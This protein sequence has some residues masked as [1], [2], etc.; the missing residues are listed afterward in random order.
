MGP[1]L[2][3][4]TQMLAVVG[5][6]SPV[7]AGQNHGSTTAVYVTGSAAATTLY[8]LDEDLTSSNV[9]GTST[10][11]RNSLWRYDIGTATQ[12]SGLPT[13]VNTAVG[14][15]LVPLASSDL[16]RGANGNFYLAQNRA[17]GNEAGVIVLSADGSTVLFN[18]LD[19][20]RALLANPAAVDIL[21]NI[22]GIAV[23]PDQ[24]YLAGMLNNS[25]VVVLRLD[26]LGI[27]DLAN[28]LVIDTGTDIIS[29]RD[30]TFDAA[31]NIHYVSS[32]QA[33]YRVLAPGGFTY[34][35]TSWDGS[36]FSFVVVPEPTTALLVGAGSLLLLRRRR[37]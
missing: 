6:P 4:P 13:K 18:S 24:K 32:G 19:A 10:S 28:R 16:D 2:T 5:G 1:T 31:D 21:R 26:A 9:G 36:A 29:G 15:A 25:D 35:T 12:Y 33:L 7:P 37:I 22:Q 30:I 17:A 34:A 20:S 23:S 14:G 27:P 8:T 3:A 11:D